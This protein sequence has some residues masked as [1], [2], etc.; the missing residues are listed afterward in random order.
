[1]HIHIIIIDIP[2]RVPVELM[3]YVADVV[4]VP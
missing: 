1:M 3:L 4:I 2:E